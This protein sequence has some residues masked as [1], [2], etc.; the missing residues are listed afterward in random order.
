MKTEKSRLC[1]KSRHWLSGGDAAQ[2]GRSPA[3]NGEPGPESRRSGDSA[4]R[5]D[6][7]ATDDSVSVQPAV[8]ISS[9]T[10]EGQHSGTGEGAVG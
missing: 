4:A 10:L 5:E 3:V 2:T 6:E 1:Q 7:E 9:I 8:E